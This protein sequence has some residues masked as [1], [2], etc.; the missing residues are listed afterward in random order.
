MGG[1]TS[2][3]LNAHDNTVGYGDAWQG[4]PQRRP[5]NGAAYNDCEAV[6]FSGA[7]RYSLGRSTRRAHVVVCLVGAKYPD[8]SLCVFTGT[9]SLADRSECIGTRWRF[10]DGTFAC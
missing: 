3:S 1:F 2:P 9:R 10:R 6:G 8:V 4:D 5:L 7:L